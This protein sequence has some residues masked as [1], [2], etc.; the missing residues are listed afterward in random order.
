MPV[1]HGE[2]HCTAST[3]R[4]SARSATNR[5]ETGD[6]AEGE[7]AVRH[8]R[9]C[10]AGRRPGRPGCEQWPVARPLGCLFARGTGAR[11]GAHASRRRRGAGGVDRTAGMD[12]DLERPSS[13]GSSASRGASSSPARATTSR[14]GATGWPWS[15]S[16][17]G[18]AYACATTPGWRCACGPRPGRDAREAM[19]YRWYRARFRNCVPEVL[20]EWEPRVACGWPTG[21]SAE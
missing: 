13:P 10:C 15:S 17:V 7:G 20:A 14:V 2:G 5:P 16:P 4:R 18:W 9:I 3:L 8:P 1:G 19:L 6:G 12:T 11:C 21:A